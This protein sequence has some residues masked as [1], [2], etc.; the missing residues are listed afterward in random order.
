M[1]CQTLRYAPLWFVQPDPV[2]HQPT[3]GQSFEDA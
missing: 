1:S 3:P 2:L